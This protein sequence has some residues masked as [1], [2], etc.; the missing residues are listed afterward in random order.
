MRFRK[1]RIAWSVGWGL[2][3]VL[4]I[5]LWVRSYWYR[6]RIILGLYGNHALQFGHVLGQVRLHWFEQPGLDFWQ[7]SD[8]I[9]G[10]SKQLIADWKLE[11]SASKDFPGL[12]PEF[13]RICGKS[14][15]VLYLPYWFPVLVAGTVAIVPW[16]RWRFSLRT[17]LIATTLVAVLLGL[18]VYAAR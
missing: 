13:G 17:L 4:L 2:L 6:E 8:S 11:R 10:R 3:A 5:V 18:L 16:L 1:L 15:W 9:W 7:P 12:R 14:G